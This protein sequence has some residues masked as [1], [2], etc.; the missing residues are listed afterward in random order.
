MGEDADTYL[1]GISIPLPFN[2]NKGGIQA[3]QHRAVKS[4]ELRRSM[5]IRLDIAL[6][7]SHNALSS[8]YSRVTALRDTVLPGAQSAFDSVNEG[9]RLGRFG[10]LDVLDSQRTLFGAQHEYL[11]AAT[12]YHR[13]VVDVERLIGDR[14]DSTPTKQDGDLP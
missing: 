11:Q 5:E 4:A 12:D 10:L 9:Y 8:A 1:V 2:R 7:E 14:L 13:A 6:A 3:A